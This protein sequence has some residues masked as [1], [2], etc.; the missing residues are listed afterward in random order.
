MV[1]WIRIHLPMQG[2]EV[3]SLVWEDP[4]NHGAAKPMSHNCQAPVPRAPQ[5]EEPTKRNKAD[6]LP[7]GASESTHSR[8]DPA[9]P[10]EVLKTNR[11][12]ASQG[13]PALRCGPG[14]GY[15]LKAGGTPWLRRSLW[16]LLNDT[17]TCRLRCPHKYI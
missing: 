14:S 12:C 15:H 8:A 10:T 6:S 5:R 11:A 1:Q 9:Q 3:Q 16:G 13:D 2:T 7:T 17:G 4:A